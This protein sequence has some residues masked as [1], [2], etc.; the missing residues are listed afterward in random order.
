MRNEYLSREPIE[1]GF[2][3]PVSVWQEIE[4]YWDE[5]PS[6]ALE[7]LMAIG[8]YCFYGDEPNEETIG[9]DVLRS[10]RA[11]IPL[12][13][14]QRIRYRKAK[15]GGKSY[16][17]IDDETFLSVLES[18]I[19]ETQADLAR[20][21]Q[22]SRQAVSQRLKRMGRTLNSHTETTTQTTPSPVPT[23]TSEVLKNWDNI[24]N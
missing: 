17:K 2:N 1:E 24:I 16:N 15:G 13:D 9:R 14:N 10:V 22:I 8:R 12:I 5:E 11:Q 20:E 18:R 21:L 4:D 19:W 23:N 7:Y 3:I 6:K